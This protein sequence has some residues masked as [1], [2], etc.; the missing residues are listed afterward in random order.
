MLLV[1]FHGSDPNHMRKTVRLAK[2]H[3]TKIGAHFS[4]RDLAGFGSEK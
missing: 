4:L 2:Q 1:A 3:N